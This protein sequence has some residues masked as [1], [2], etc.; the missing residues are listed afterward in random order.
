MVREDGCAEM[1]GTGGQT[2]SA[3]VRVNPRYVALTLA[4]TRALTPAGV[5]LNVP[6][7]CPALIDSEAGRVSAAGLSVARETVTAASGA[8][9]RVTVPLVI[10]PE[11]AGD[12][13][14]V[15]AAIGGFAA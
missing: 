1:E 4:A 9:R 14:K 5:T 6:T 8:A 15:S 12:G 13:L 3:V 11:S 7:V 2:S 10:V